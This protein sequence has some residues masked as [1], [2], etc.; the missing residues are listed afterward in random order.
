MPRGFDLFLIGVDI[1]GTF[2]DVVI[3]DGKHPADLEILKFS[4]RQGEEEK[5]VVESLSKHSQS[6]SQVLLIAHATTVGTNALLTNKGLAKT[7]LIT[8][9]GFRDILE[10]G[11]QRRPEVYNL[12]TQR[13]TPLVQR[14]DRF[15]VKGRT[16]SDG[17]VIERTDKHEIRKIAS[18][19]EESGFDAV[20]ICLLNSY[21]NP[22]QE[23]ETRDN[24]REAGFKGR[25]DISS[26][27]DPSYRE[28]ERTSTTVVNASL[29]KPVSKYLT[30]LET[31]IRRLG[32]QCPLY[33]MNSDGTVSTIANASA[34]PISLIESGPAAGLVASKF[35]AKRVHL[36]NALTFDMG[37][38]TAKAGTVVNYQPELA[39]E[40]E[41]AGRSYHGRSMKGSGYPV[42]QQFIDLAEVSAGGGTIAWRDEGGDLR[43]GPDSAGADPGPAAYGKGG[44]RPT[45]TDANMVAGRINPSGLLGGNLKTHYDLAAD[46]IGK[47]ARQLDESIAETARNII[48]IVN[49]NMSKA[50]RLVTVERGRDPREFT[51]IAFGGAGPLH[52]CDLA[53]E[54]GIRRI[55]VPPHPGMFS[56]FGLLTSDLSRSF[57]RPIMRPASANLEAYFVNLRK[58]VKATLDQESFPVFRTIEQVDLR[59][60]GQAYEITLPYRKDADMIRLFAQEHRRLY[61]YSSQDQV[62]AVN[63]RLRAVIGIPKAKLAK[64][65]PQAQRP[66]GSRSR[67]VHLQNNSENV[68]VFDREALLGGRSGKGPCIIEEYDSTTLVQKSWDWKMDQFGDIEMTARR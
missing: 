39:N 6:A 48:R 43:V 4:T 17:N 32:F 33:V 53:D 14:R 55:V 62:E 41:A 44:I 65:K 28:Y 30:R 29:S 19:L 12:K 37:G 38:T 54:L 63:A 5:T 46:A 67:R 31:E 2:T 27:T 49:S 50:L 35:L 60:R 16:F 7:A 51:L 10:I 64:A 1:G 24:I 40:F 57:S 26:E 8:N 68:A 42:R 52:A 25:V 3:F 18:T 15:T 22:Q 13:P 45:V 11:R 59:Y 56:A 58:L 34:R 66:A 23:I 47:L 20:A 21:A 9:G 61:G 36:K